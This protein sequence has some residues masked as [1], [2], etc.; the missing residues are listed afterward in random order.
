MSEKEWRCFYCN[1]PMTRKRARGS[2]GRP[3]KTNATTDHIVPQSKWNAELYDWIG[4]NS[5]N[6]NCVRV[7]LDCNGKKANMWPLEWIVIMPQSGVGNLAKRLRRLGCDR[8][9]IDLAISKRS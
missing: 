3:L 9:E 8:G 2:N 6:L 5:Q 1:V 7:C 4:G